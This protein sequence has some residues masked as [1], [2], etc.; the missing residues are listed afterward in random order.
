LDT[1]ERYRGG[2]AKRSYDPANE[3]VIAEADSRS[4]A[5]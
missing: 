1:G 5:P 2:H 3:V 4:L